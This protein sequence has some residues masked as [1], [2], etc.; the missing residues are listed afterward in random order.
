MKKIILSI[1]LAFIFTFGCNTAI[2]DDNFDYVTQTFVVTLDSSVITNMYSSPYEILPSPGSG[3]YIVVDTANAHFVPTVGSNYSGGGNV[4][5]VEC[6]GGSYQTQL[7]V[8]S[9]VINSGVEFFTYAIYQNNSYYHESDPVCVTNLTSA[10]SGNGG[11][12]TFYLQYHVVDISSQSFVSSTDSPFFPP[13]L[14]WFLEFGVLTF[15]F[16][17]VMKFIIKYF[18]KIL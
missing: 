3:K 12:L 13:G 10:F 2:A 9:S 4:R 17:Y 11:T 7:V 8:S 1:I 18:G 14:V 16:F 5:L 6:S 15:L